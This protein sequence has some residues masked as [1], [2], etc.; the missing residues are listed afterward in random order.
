MKKTTK[1]VTVASHQFGY[2]VRNNYE[3]V[4]SACAD[5]I[6]DAIKNALKIAKREHKGLI[7]TD[8]FCNIHW[9]AEKVQGI[10]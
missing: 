9:N 6:D 3:T 7:V 10:K 1:N 4:K 2:V 5:N 8:D